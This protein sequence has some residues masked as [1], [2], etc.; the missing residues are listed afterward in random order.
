MILDLDDLP[1]EGLDV[2]RAIDLTDPGPGGEGKWLD[3]PARLALRALPGER[4]VGL[5]GRVEAAAR[6]ECSRCLEP[7]VAPVA[8]D[9]ALTVVFDAAE[10]GAADHR[11]DPADADLLYAAE[12]RLDLGELVR[13]Q[14]LLALPLK[15]VCRADCAGLCPTCGA[16]RNRIECACRKTQVDPRFAPLAAWR[17]RRGPDPTPGSPGKDDDAESKT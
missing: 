16:N 4:G 1:D 7:C 10:F 9:F 15:P 11:M 2:E 13:E 14:V 5:S 3:A 12:G 8:V 17:E 6:V